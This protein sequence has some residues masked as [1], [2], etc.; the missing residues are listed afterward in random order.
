MGLGS[1]GPLFVVCIVGTWEHT[2]MTHC[3]LPPSIVALVTPSLGCVPK[4]LPWFTQRLYL[5]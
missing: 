1:V 4:T 2:L 5:N 3:L